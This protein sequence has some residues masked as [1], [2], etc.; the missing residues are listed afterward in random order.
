ME[1]QATVESQSGREDVV[2]RT[3]TA[4]AAV[5]VIS[6]SHRGQQGYSTWLR[7]QTHRLLEKHMVLKKNNVSG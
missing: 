3:D 7:C 1:L 6:I 4:D 2:E 5:K